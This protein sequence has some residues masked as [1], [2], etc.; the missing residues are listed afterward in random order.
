VMMKNSDADQRQAE[1]NDL[2]EWR[3]WGDWGPT[4]S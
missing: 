3:R 4:R 2:A 1:Q